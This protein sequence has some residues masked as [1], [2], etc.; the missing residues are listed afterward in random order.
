MLRPSPVPSPVGLVVKKGSKARS[1]SPASFIPGPLSATS[2]RTYSPGPTSR[3]VA[4]PIFAKGHRF[5]G[6]QGQLAALRHGVA[7]VDRKIEDGILRG[8]LPRLRSSQRFGVASIRISM[9][10][11]Q[12][13]FQHLLHVRTGVRWRP[14]VASVAVALARERQAA[15]WSG[16]RRAM[17]PFRWLPVPGRRFREDPPTTSLQ[18]IP[19]S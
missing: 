13:P 9:L 10:L 19:G 4:D 17:P 1:R 7:G 6:R 18:D 15:A 12:G 16:R 8:R 14:P 2:S 11:G 3:I 5:S